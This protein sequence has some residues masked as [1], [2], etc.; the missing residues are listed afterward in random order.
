MACGAWLCSVLLGLLCGCASQEALLV[1]Q[2]IGAGT[3]PSRL[4]VITPAPLR[5]PV[6][7]E[8]AG[9]AGSGYLY[10]P[11]KDLPRAGIVLVPGAV[12]EGKDHK[13]LVAF[14][15]TLARARFAVFVPELSGYRQLKVRATHP[16]E[17]AD[18]LLYLSARQDLLHGKRVGFAAFS[19]AV[20][21]AVLAAL[22]DDTRTQ[23]HFGLSVGGYHDLRAAIRFF[24]TGYFEANGDPRHLEPSDY[25]KLVFAKS[26]ADHLRDPRDRAIIGAMV[27]AK[28]A[29]PA[30]DI[31]LLAEG[32]GPEGSSAY[33]LITNTDPG[34][35][36]ELIDALPRD[37]IA[38][39][40]ALPLA[41]KD[42]TRL[43]ARLIL[44]HGKRDRLIPYSETLA[45]GTSVTP[46]HAHVFIINRIL[47]HVDLSLSHA[48]S[49]AFYTQYL[50]DAWRLL[51]AI[52]LLLLER[53]PSVDVP[54]EGCAP[55][56]A[57]GVRR[58]LTSHP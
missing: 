32:L 56:H 55:R 50:P 14:A 42:L 11:A 1:L 10:L 9:R 49:W 30:A 38:A 8:I 43:E 28:L 12:P 23:V 40:D 17:L 52:D 2:D 18:A 24:T 47:G 34:A 45:L 5:T 6:A 53:Q 33:R 19:Y 36:P 54:A 15:T 22:E 7:Y 58:G 13:Q 26:I 20:G 25:S 16:R 48:F 4:K 46:S 31:S 51:Q 3:G 37:A 29:D 21:P 39:I 41:N 27:D 57:N 44:V 35:T